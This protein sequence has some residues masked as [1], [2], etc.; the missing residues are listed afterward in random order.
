MI[1]SRVFKIFLPILLV[2]L[3][4]FAASTMVRMKPKAARIT[5]P[6]PRPVVTV[7]TVTSGG[8]EVR[9]KGFGTV[10]AK[11][12][13]NVVPQVSG[14]VME[15]SPIFEPGGYCTKGQLLLR[16]DNTDY[17]LAAARAEADVAQMEFNLA[18]ADEEAQVAIKEWDGMRRSSQDAEP[19]SLVLHDP[20]MKLANANLN[21][22]K[23]AL[24]QAMVNLERCTL[25]APF[26][27]R[28]LAADV[29]AGQYLRAGNAIGTL[30]ATD[31]AEVIV[32]VPDDDLAWIA[33]EGTGCTNAPQTVVDVYANF[34]GARHQWE[35]RAVRLG[36]AV[37]S[38]SRLVPVVVE[39]NDPY[40]MTGRRPPLVEGMFVEVL[41]RGTPRD[42][43]LII[44][45]SALRPNNEVWVITD[46]QKVTVRKVVVA[47]AGLDEVV[48]TSGLEPG[49]NVCTSNL[50][51]VTEGLPVRLEGQPIKPVS[52][53]G[54]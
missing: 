48:I 1:N 41:F 16:I 46:E 24:R 39:I 40:E 31:I 52:K 35:G 51:Y 36:G 26:D 2:A 17:P 37:D 28:I 29:D 5:P 20:Q 14:E 25:T 12:S 50:Q 38:H 45:R 54:A 22:A 47:R 4:L 30:Y 49:E 9:V 53:E 19:S 43:A 44:P 13:V 11:R 32:S 8:S 34:A 15:K 27:G 10:K 23:A 18:R 42:D 6:T 3:A 21:A 33:I 7:H